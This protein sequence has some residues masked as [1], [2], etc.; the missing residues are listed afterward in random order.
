MTAPPD[1]TP[2]APWWR[3]AALYQ[4]YPRSFADSN[5]DS[6]GDGI[7]DLSGITAQLDYVASLGV[8]G[9]WLSP[10][11]PSPMRDFGYDVADHCGVSPMF[12]T[13]A[14][15]DALVARA[16]A[17]NLKALIDQVWSHTA[18]EHPWAVFTSG[19]PWLPVPPAHRHLA[20]DAQEAN[21]KSTL[22]FTRS[23]LAL[24][25]RHA[26]LRLGSFEALHADDTLLVLRRQH[27]GDAVLA[28]FNLGAEP[29]RFDLP[30]ALR[31]S[32][33][34]VAVAGATV[35]ASALHLPPQSALIVPLAEANS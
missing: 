3:G 33:G 17:L 1:A 28:A 30:Q 7:G 24:R 6:N 9:L 23:L 16:H 26:A 18:Q 20:V 14:D 19:R 4:I 29:R 8:D 27:A 21:A 34:V 11:F 13:L 15:F 22:H 31:A 2:P 5:G 35:E 10:F 12:G 25:R 32:D